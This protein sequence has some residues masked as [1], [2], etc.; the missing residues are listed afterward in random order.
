MFKNTFLQLSA[1]DDIDAYSS[2]KKQFLMLKSIMKFYEKSDELI[3]KGINISEI[4]ES[5][6]YQELTRMRF[7][8][9]ESKEDMD[10]L[11]GL[12]AEVESSLEG[13]EF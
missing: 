13:L 5:P 2:S 1:F 9:S 12:P 3:K 7:K 11:A 6:I 4:K 10:K 8:Y